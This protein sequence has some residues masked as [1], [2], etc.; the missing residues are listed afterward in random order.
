MVRR[1][2]TVKGIVQGVGFRPFV[3]KIA[4][5]NNLKGWVKNTSKGVYIDVEGTIEKINSFT[6]N[7][8]H[9]SP[10][11]SKIEEIIIEN[12]Q[13]VNYK[14]FKIEKSDREKDTVTLIPPDMG[15]C[16]DCLR[17]IANPKNRRYRYPFTNCTNCG[18]RFSIIQKLPY[19]RPATTMDKFQMCDN[20]CYEYMNPLNRRFHA[21]PNACPSCGPKVELIDNCGY[22]IICID[23]IKEA[24]KFIKKG[25]IIAVKGLGGFHLSCDAKNKKAV[26][27]LRN[28]KHR[29]KKPLALMMKDIDT[30][31]KY[32]NI[33]AKEEEVI[34]SNK[35]PIVLLNRKISQLPENIAPN[36]NKLGV[37]LPFTPLHYLLFDENIEVLIMT[38]ANPSG[39]PIIYRNKEAIEILKPIAD[40][41]LIHNRDI[42]TPIDDSVVVV[43]L[44][45]ERVLRSAR[46]YS[47]VYIDIKNKRNILACG[48][49]LK[50]TFALSKNNK[51]FISQYIGNIE[52]LETYNRF[53]NILSHIKKIY[54]LTPSVIAY[55]IHPNY[56]SMEYAAR[57]D[58]EKIPVQ[59]HHAHIVSCMV[60]NDI[61]D[62]VIGITYDGIGYGTDGSIWGGEFLL[63]DYK[64]FKRVGHI[65]YVR[66]PGGDAAT[67]E[68]WKMAIS[69][70][71]NA[72]GNEVYKYMP[73]VLKD[74]NIGPVLYM[75][76]N[77]INSPQCSS[78][79]RLFDAVSAITGYTGRITFEGE[80]AILLESMADMNENSRYNYDIEFKNEKY[81]INTNRIIREIIKDINIGTGYNFI[82]NKFHNT[83]MDFSVEM[84]N[85]IAEKYKIYKIVLSG[86]VFQNEILFK[87]I[88]EKLLDQGFEVYTHKIIPCND[89]GISLGQIVIAG[90]NCEN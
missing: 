32:C 14:G 77:N 88:Y 86:G 38:S 3:Y 10:I 51:I 65:N 62:N 72:Y 82:S 5:E 63:C 48:S 54:N 84:C 79:G 34:T 18:P 49:Q 73:R 60:E 76:K 69:Y 40:Y 55:D 85:I 74:R 70:I 89:S 67:K 21:Q 87:G 53:E 44:N 50:N 9:K 16:K 33:N 52:N 30:V 43:T 90:A 1:Y 61:D 20:C 25:K 37:M 42:Y 56:W 75:I 57:Q 19:D 17:D 78:M 39:I 45:K 13:L 68:P 31:K 7:L 27:I 29:P 71:Y 2:I 47:P 36:N 80:A 81:I 64:D 83:L 46:G 58:I 66:M 12:R 41:F 35:R 59:H 4:R 28:R 15:I 24:A 11:V 26:Q 23:P 22:K 8:K 6:Y